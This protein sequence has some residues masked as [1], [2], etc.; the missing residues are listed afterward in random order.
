MESAGLAGECSLKFVDS[1]P[2]GKEVRAEHTGDSFNVVV[3]NRLTS[4]RKERKIR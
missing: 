2:G 4:I 3:I 1:G